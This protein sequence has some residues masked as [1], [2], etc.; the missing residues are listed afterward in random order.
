MNDETVS[1]NGWFSGVLEREVGE[2]PCQNCGRLVAVIVPFLG[3]VFCSE[4]MESD[5][6]EL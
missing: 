4:C 5:K 6:E 3:C 1:A 2:V